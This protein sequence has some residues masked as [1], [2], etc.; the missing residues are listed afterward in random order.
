MFCTGTSIKSGIKCAITETEHKYGQN[1]KMTLALILG[2]YFMV[3]KYQRG[4]PS[5]MVN[6]MLSL[7]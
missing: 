7:F 6:F 3:N 4:S 1:L 5:L 2:D